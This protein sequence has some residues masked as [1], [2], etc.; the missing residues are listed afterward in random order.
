MNFMFGK[1]KTKKIA[2]GG[3][4]LIEL[5]VVIAIIAILAAMLLPA[6]AKAKFR[7]KVANCI[8]NYHQWGT[9]VAVYASDDPEGKMP[10]FYVQSSGGN[11][12]DVASNFCILCQPFG[13]TVQM[14]FCPVRPADF[15]L[16][17]TQFKNGF[18][19]LGAQHR[20]LS[21]LADLNLWAWKA[22]SNNGMF[23]KLLY[24]W[25]VPRVSNAI[26]VD[27]GLFPVPDA[28]NNGIDFPGMSGGV[29]PSDPVAQPWPLKT[30]DLTVSTQPII[31][32][33]AEANGDTADINTIPNTEAHFYNGS[34]DSI[35]LGFADGHAETH[36]SHQ[37]KFQFSGN[38]KSQSYFY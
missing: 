23:S 14:Y 20:D 35:N 32:D 19:N 15:D 5:L 2:Q 34:L 9:M 21:S 7:A 16:A 27:A 30:S 18:G 12:T 25:W 8:S 6:L 22:K 26:V 1:L 10:S 37:I 11:P 29:D 24:D 13:M 4:T 36:N 3:F 31:S 28:S 38:G 33:L 17:D